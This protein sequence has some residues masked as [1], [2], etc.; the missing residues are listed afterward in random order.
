MGKSPGKWIKT[1][2]FGKK[3]S[4][5]GASK[6]REALRTTNAKEVW[7][8]GKAPPAEVAVESPVISQPVPVAT[9]KNGGNSALEKGVTS[10]VT[11]DGGVSMPVDQ[12]AENQGAVRSDASNDLVKF[13]EEQA[14]I[15]A[16]AAF[17][18]Y[19]ARRAFRAL[20][21]IIRLQALIRGHLVRRQAVATLHCL[22]GI[23]KLQALV[24]G[25]SVRCSDI[26]VEIQKKCH[27]DK[28][29]DAK[30]LDSLG[31]NTSTQMENLLSNAFVSK[32]LS[33]QPVAMPLQ[34]QYGQGEPNSAWNWL[35]R[36]SS[37]F[38]RDALSQTKKTAS[39]SQTKQG[40]SH[41]VETES[42]RPKRSVRRNPAANIDSSSTNSPSDLEK[43]K[44]NLRKVTSHP[45][46][47]AQENPQNELEK[48]KRN[49]R[50]VSSSTSEVSERVETENEKPKRS[51][52]KVTSSPSD[53]PDQG[54]VDS[55]EKMK[56]DTAVASENHPEAETASK[57]VE[58]A[59]KLVETDAPPV[60][61]L[62]DDHPAVEL[63]P[64][65]TSGK[66]GNI[67]PMNGELTTKEDQTRHENQKT[68]KR[69]ASFPAKPEYP[70]NDLQNTPTLP[71]Y[72][73]AT[74][75]AKAKLRA[76]SSPKFGQDGTEKNGFT[77]R[78]SLP[79]AT[80]G[81]VS[82]PSIRAQRLVQ[83][84]GKGAVRSDRSLS[85]RDGN[86]KV[87]QAEWRR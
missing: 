1:V 35:E 67:S 32:L 2:L 11:C 29:M 49:L 85:S 75:S 68:T 47:S 46:D 53:V 76:Q 63:P 86:E 25:Q 70:E 69:R 45:I 27:Q 66:D 58:T 81:K 38:S 51:V 15:K 7:I 26:G 54:I 6:G 84:S 24:R 31:V 22:Q 21:G 83:A 59:S 48:V 33:P 8:T 62:H 80:N 78:H 64:L 55:V 30:L 71:S 82:S 17:R 4:R 87:I 10:N 23:V 13:K 18:G 57:P 40:G 14:A 39:K 65:E 36:W 52:R 43:P 9:D 41:A 16:Q 19:L 42:G 3:S 44:R 12:A 61:M 79:S 20:K 74:E 73:A 37:T 56:K 34:I 50:K 72:M 5:S 28:P 77:R 60:D